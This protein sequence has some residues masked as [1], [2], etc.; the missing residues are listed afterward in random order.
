MCEPQLVQLD[1]RVDTCKF[2]QGAGK[3]SHPSPEITL[4]ANKRFY[5][6]S[7]LENITS[8]KF[9]EISHGD[10][11]IELLDKLTKLFAK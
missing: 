2:Y 4:N 7:N 1:C 10:S 9:G 6:W 3:C 5:C 8:P 11:V